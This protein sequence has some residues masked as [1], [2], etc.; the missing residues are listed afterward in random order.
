MDESALDELG[1]ELHSGIRRG[2]ED[3]IL[4]SQ[5]K[6]GRLSPLPGDE[7]ILSGAMSFSDFAGDG[8]LFDPPESHVGCFPAIERLAVEDRFEAGASSR[9]SGLVG[10]HGKRGH[11]DEQERAKR[12][13]TFVLPSFREVCHWFFSGFCAVAS[14][15]HL[16]RAPHLEFLAAGRE[17]HLKAR[18]S[19]TPS[20]YRRS[21]PRFHFR[22]QPVLESHRT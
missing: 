9:R 20:T 19:S 1:P 13:Q 10:R 15:V 5:L 17:V 11:N 18:F 6:V 8:A 21:R 2:P 4:E 7:D 3:P 16:S 14:H 12:S 22:C